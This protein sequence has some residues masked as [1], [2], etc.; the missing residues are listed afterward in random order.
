MWVIFINFAKYASCYKIFVWSGNIL[1]VGEY[2]YDDTIIGGPHNRSIVVVRK[3]QNYLY[4]NDG[5]GVT[6]K[7]VELPG[8]KS[9]VIRVVA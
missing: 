6:V 1:F 9:T 4:E 8:S 2:S 3:R 5:G 7:T